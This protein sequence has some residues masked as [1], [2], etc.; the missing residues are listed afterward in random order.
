LAKLAFAIRTLATKC[1]I[2]HGVALDRRADTGEPL[3][4]GRRVM[5]Q[6]GGYSVALKLV[7]AVHRAAGLSGMLTRPIGKKQ[8]EHYS[9]RMLGRAVTSVKSSN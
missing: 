8:N 9:W 5:V 1:S 4:Q 7:E 3:I 6:F 2:S